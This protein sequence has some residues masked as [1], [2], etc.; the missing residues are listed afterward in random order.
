[1]QVVS[2]I[3][4]SHP[5]RQILI[6]ASEVGALMRAIGAV[7]GAF[8]ARWAGPLRTS[9]E[10]NHF[11]ASRKVAQVVRHDCIMRRRSDRYSARLYAA[12]IAVR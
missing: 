8:V 7:K 12:L 6:Q 9:H 3:C 10:R 1:M 4:D 2:L 11:A 5:L